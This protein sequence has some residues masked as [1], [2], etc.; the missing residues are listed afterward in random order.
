MIDTIYFSLQ[1]A[2][3]LFFNVLCIL[4]IVGVF[5]TIG[6]VIQIKTKAEEALDTAKETMNNVGETTTSVRDMLGNFGGFFR[7]KKKS[8]VAEII[9]IFLRR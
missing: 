5:L 2:A 4:A 7:P 9:E 3:L 1:F 6:A 8:G